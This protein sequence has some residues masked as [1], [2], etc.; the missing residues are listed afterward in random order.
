MSDNRG[1]APLHNVN[2]LRHGARS[3][4]RTFP[5]TGLGRRF[6]SVNQ[7]ASRLRRRLESAVV[8]LRGALSLADEA[9]VSL[10]CSWEQTRQVA[11]RRLAMGESTDALGDCK[12]SSYAAEQR[13]KAIRKLGL[14]DERRAEPSLWDEADRL[15]S[16]EASHDVDS[17]DSGAGGSEHDQGDEGPSGGDVEGQGGDEEGGVDWTAVDGLPHPR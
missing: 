17:D 12:V 4:R 8:E 13:N 9:T 10:A 16:A 11:L 1:G 7:F 3:K 15:M 5:L 14:E 6:T 2:A